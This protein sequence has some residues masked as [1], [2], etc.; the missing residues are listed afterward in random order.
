MEYNDVNWSKTGRLRWLKWT[1]NSGEI[2][3]RA[4]EDLGSQSE[5]ARRA[6]IGKQHISKY[7]RGDIK[8]MEKET[9][10]KLAPHIRPYLPPGFLPVREEGAPWSAE[11]SP[12]PEMKSI[13][14]ISIAQ[15]AG[16]DCTLEPFDDYASVPS[17]MRRPPCSRRRREC[18]PSG[19]PEIP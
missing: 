9:W 11:V 16:F 19:S 14:V 8:K 2:L 13:P 15:A 7:I 10:E 4:A 1:G 6:G 12:A 5:L 18:S 3:R 17:I